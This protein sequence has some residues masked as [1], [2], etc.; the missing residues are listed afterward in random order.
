MRFEAVRYALSSE[1]LVLC[2]CRVLT[3]HLRPRSLVIKVAVVFAPRYWTVATALL[4]IDFSDSE[5]W[6][7]QA[8]QGLR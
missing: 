8:S 2:L 5:A 6:M 4:Y 1:V 3:F 7:P